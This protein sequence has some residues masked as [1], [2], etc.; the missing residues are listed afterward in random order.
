MLMLGFYQRDHCSLLV[1]LSF[2]AASATSDDRHRTL[3]PC[4]LSCSN[5][6]VIFRVLHVVF[7]SAGVVLRVVS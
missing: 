2:T 3:P 1:H 6:C 5:L 4:R 7:P